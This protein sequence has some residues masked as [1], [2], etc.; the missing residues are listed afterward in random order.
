MQDSHHDE[1]QVIAAVKVFARSISSSRKVVADMTAL[2]EATNQLPL[3]NLE[4][5]ERL[6]RSEFYA[7]LHEAEQ[8][9]LKFW[10]KSPRPNV[11]TWLDLISHDGYKRETILCSLSGGAPNRF[12]FA[13]ALRRLNDWVAPVRAAAREKLPQLAKASNAADVTHALCVTLH[14]WDSWGRIEP[15][16][17]AIILQLLAEQN[18]A[19]ALKASIISSS[20]G[21][22]ARLLAQIGRT[23][24]LDNCLEEIAASA[25]QPAVR[26]RA[27]RS[28][29]EGR[30]TW[31]E[32]RKYEWTDIR[33]CEGRQVVVTGERKLTITTPFRNLL[34]RSAND[35]SSLVRRIAAEFFIRELATLGEDATQLA[36]Q[37]AADA[38]GPV[39]ERGRF[40]LKQLE[41]IRH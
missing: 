1:K 14:H 15:E 8:P 36:R 19:E 25:I 13:L 2:I 40:A 17:K 7:A 21:P 9:V 38:S 5:W 16:G 30:M 34:A 18:T 10:K 32:G 27:Y 22:M 31:P 11:L 20:T 6:I 23:S 24:A 26:A 33:Y 29:F 41:T 35:P 12:F 3:S 39:A 28:L 4:Y 37:F